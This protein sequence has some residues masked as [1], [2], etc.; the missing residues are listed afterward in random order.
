MTAQPAGVR[1]ST[2]AV[3]GGRS[4]R[5]RSPVRHASSSPREGR[6]ASDRKGTA[7]WLRRCRR[8]HIRQ[9]FTLERSACPLS[10][11]AITDRPDFRGPAN[12][13]LNSRFGNVSA[14]RHHPQR[15]CLLAL[16]QAFAMTRA[17][18][19]PCCHCRYNRRCNWS[20]SAL[21]IAYW[22]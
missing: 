4:R 20:T 18:Q 17:F 7:I 14:R 10:T 19:R 6:P 3:A 5:S 2:A 1:K 16:Q 8:L 21:V 22:A 12:T 13:S 15:T 11:D 9:R